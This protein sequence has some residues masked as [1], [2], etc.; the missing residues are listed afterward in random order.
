MRIALDAMGGDRAPAAQ[1]EGALLALR[2]FDDLDVVLV[3]DP[4]RIE[5][6]LDR[7]EA[8]PEERRRLPIEVAD[9]VAAMH[10]DPVRVVR[11]NVGNSA[12]RCAE[13]L[14]DGTVKGVVNMGSTGAAV[15]AAQLFV[16]R[17]KGVRRPGIAVP[18]PRKGGATIVVDCGANSEAKAEDLLQYTV[19]AGLYARS[20][21]VKEPRVG[22]LSIGEE[23]QKGNRLVK[24][25]WALF[26][27]HEVPNFVGNVE[28]REFFHDKADVVVADGF[29]GNV[30]LKAAEGMAEYLLGA[31]AEA[32]ERGDCRKDLVG[33]VAAR[34]DYQEY[35]GAPLLGV[36]GAYIIG[37]GRSN[38]RAVLSALKAARAYE[39]HHVSE[40]TVE[41]LAESG[42]SSAELAAGGTAE[43]AAGSTGGDRG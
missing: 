3:G 23:E 37:H 34:T 26:R 25:V 30:A 38:A 7:L 6:E 39:R 20:M 27:Q 35:G 29:S 13:L 17:L 1:V 10:D 15:A 43:L 41:E 12:R 32:A 31:I 11:N 28:P 8:S 22:V 21:G 14:R 9:H 2:A 42:T 24:E 19:M 33:Q 5:A 4:V 40:R 36:K 16:G 18:F